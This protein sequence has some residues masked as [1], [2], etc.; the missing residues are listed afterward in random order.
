MVHP[1]QTVSRQWGWGVI[2]AVTVE[3]LPSLYMLHFFFFF[4]FFFAAFLLF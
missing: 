2:A 4:F 1:N 3:D